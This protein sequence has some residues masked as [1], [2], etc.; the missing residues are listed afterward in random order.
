MKS[1]C[2]RADGSGGSVQGASIGGG[3]I[4]VDLVNDMKVDFNGESNTL[5]VMHLDRPGVIAAVTSLM[6][7]EYA[8]L[9]I[10]NFHLSRERRGGDAIMTIE[11]DNQ[12]PD[13][14][15]GDIRK[16]ENVTNALLIRRL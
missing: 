3:N 12:P 6:R 2:R 4:R 1:G 10:C 15:I 8:D 7:W 5:L 9:N 11:I 13:T 16:L 14:L